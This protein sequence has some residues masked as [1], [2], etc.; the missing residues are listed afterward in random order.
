MG[1]IV[2]LDVYTETIE[3]S[4]FS[5]PGGT[6]RIKRYEDFIVFGPRITVGKPVADGLSSLLK[7]RA[8]WRR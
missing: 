6:K 2:C 5:H 3:S 1:N 8:S 7:E 4:H